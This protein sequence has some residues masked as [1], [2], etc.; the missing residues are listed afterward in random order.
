LQNEN[1]K[2]NKKNENKNDNDNKNEELKN[3]EEII[4]ILKLNEI[5]LN[6]LTK[7]LKNVL[8]TKLNLN[9]FNIHQ[10]ILVCY[11]H[12]VSISIK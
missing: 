4:K 1:E 11:M 12:N 2:I 10:L 7:K 5:N 8:K 9:A 6:L 3:N